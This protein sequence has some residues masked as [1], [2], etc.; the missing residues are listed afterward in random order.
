[1]R[2]KSILITF[3]LLLTLFIAPVQSATA[4]SV[5]SVPAP[6]I[7]T[8]ASGKSQSIL[9]QP[10]APKA[11]AEKKSNFIVDFNTV[12]FAAQA[13]VQAAI[14]VWAENFSSNYTI[15]FLEK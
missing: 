10:T 11:Y 6:W 14:D 7:Y 4:Y 15:Y 5:K 9:Q 13:A 3:G 1:M 8:Y 12:P 2:R